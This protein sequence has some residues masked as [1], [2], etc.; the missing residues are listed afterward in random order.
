MVIDAGD[1]VPMVTDGAEEAMVAFVRAAIERGLWYAATHLAADDLQR[2]VA[3]RVKADVAAG[4]ADEL[5]TSLV[6][7][8]DN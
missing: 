5:I 2:G 4:S 3:H 7:G 1:A 6:R 8:S